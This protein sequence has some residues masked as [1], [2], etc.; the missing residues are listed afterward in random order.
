M[1]IELTDDVVEKFARAHWNANP[2][3]ERTHGEPW[4][5]TGWRTRVHSYVL[6]D[7]EDMS[8]SDRQLWRHKTLAAFYAV[9]IE[10][11]EGEDHG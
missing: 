10:E 8:E 5:D 7:D 6:W 2:T 3:A 11:R 9:S 1:Q 4:G